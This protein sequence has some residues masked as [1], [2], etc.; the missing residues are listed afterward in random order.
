MNREILKGIQI[1][2][3]SS[4]KKLLEYTDSYKGILIAI[5][6]EKIIN[7]DRQMINIINKNL[8][9]IDGIGPLWA[10]KN[11]GYKD[12]CKIPG[13]ELWLK[14]I[15]N[16][17]ICKSFYLL[18]AKEEVINAT[19]CKLREEF[20]S[21]NICGYHNGFID[22]ENDYQDVINEIKNLK[23]DIVFVAMGSPRQEKFMA[24]A[25]K[26][27]EALYMGLGGSFD[28]YAGL[29]KRAPEWWLNHNLEFAYRLLSDPRRIKR[30]IH[31]VKFLWW[32][33]LNKI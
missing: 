1:G 28:I 9:Y 24:E 3:F 31:L 11:K 23:P 6:A 21:I 8:G 16:S 10:L 13:C 7:A 30:Q 19:V 27:H 2:L 26:H 12:I 18:G 17:Y 15:K 32:I 33:L 14:I 25:L 5:N 20:P 4:D 22:N 29:T